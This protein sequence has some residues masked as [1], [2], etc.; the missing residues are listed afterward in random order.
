MCKANERAARE[1][2]RVAWSTASAM[3]LQA[4]DLECLARFYG[5]T[6]GCAEISREP[7]RMWLF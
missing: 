1:Q 6:L 4:R 5:R 7:D 3:T 2:R